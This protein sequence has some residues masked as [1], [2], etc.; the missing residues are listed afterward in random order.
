MEIV[1]KRSF[2][3]AM[4]LAML[5]S[6]ILPQAALAYEIKGDKNYPKL[7]IH[8][9][10]QEPG[11]E[12]GE[13]AGNPGEAAT[14]KPLSG[15]EFT[16]TQTHV[17]NSTTDEWTEVSGTPFTRVTD[18][19]GQIVI[20]NIELGRYKVQETNGPAHVNLN[21]EEYFVDIPMTNRAGNELNYDVHIYPKNETIRGAVELLKLDG[22]SGLSLSNVVFDLY[23]SGDNLL[24]EGLI[25]DGDGYIRVNSLE[26]GDYYFKEVSAPEGYVVFG[27]KIDFSITDSGTVEIDGTKTGTVET[28]TIENYKEPRIE[29]TIN[30]STEDYETNR[31]TDFTYDLTIALPKDIQ[32]Y[33]KFI[34][35]DTLDD[36]LTYTE[37]WSVE[38]IDPSILDFEQNGQTLTWKINNFSALEGV[39]SFTI[40]FTAEVN[41]DAPIERI[42]NIGGIEFTN[43][44]GTDGD[45]ETPPVYVTPTE[46]SLK[47]I[48][49]DPEAGE[50]LA[51]AEFELRDL[52]GNVIESDTTDGNGEISWTELDYGKYKLVETK[53]PEGYRIL[54]NPIDVTI[55]NDNKNITLTVDNYQ[56]GWE[57][58]ATGGIG[59]ILFTIIGLCIMGTAIYLYVRRKKEVA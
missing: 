50:K 49:Q 27:E 31:E 21:T 15:V 37:N 5:L 56:S 16:L 20:E 35:T 48:K 57:L 10:E 13:G 43:R 41:G 14:G 46:G 9:Y 28:I 3:I 26:F 34:V 25:T 33:Q 17:Y 38:G 54:K 51:G 44:T 12:Q 55:N 7:T 19:N 8:K 23:D 6:L 45:K 36:R 42:P 22:D 52:D 58:P 1:K 47:I 30:G 29:K 32:D 11:E 39:E 2:N 53:A 24:E 4:V 18:T 59:T 40:H